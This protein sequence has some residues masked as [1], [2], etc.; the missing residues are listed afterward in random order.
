MKKLK[1]R[2]WVK[3]TMVMLSVVGI[4]VLLNNQYENAVDECVNN[5]QS[6]AVCFNNLK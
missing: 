1:L 4:F 6:Y 2:N 3:T 5:G